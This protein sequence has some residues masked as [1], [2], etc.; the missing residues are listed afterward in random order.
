MKQIK[1]FALVKNTFILVCLLSLFSCKSDRDLKYHELYSKF[2]YLRIGCQT[3]NMDALLDKQQDIILGRKHIGKND[4][5]LTPS[6]L[7][8]L[9]AGITYVEFVPSEK[10]LA[11]A[12]ALVSKIKSITPLLREVDSICI[13][14]TTFYEAGQKIKLPPDQV[15]KHSSYEVMDK[16]LENINKIDKQMRDILGMSFVDFFVQNKK[17]ARVDMEKDST[18]FFRFFPMLR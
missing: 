1:L 18:V 9:N 7:E 14:A 12:N 17:E 13:H 5:N 4:E 16:D 15:V 2:F 10:E 6:E 11:D 8:K 3:A